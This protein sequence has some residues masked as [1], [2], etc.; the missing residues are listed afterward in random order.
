MDENPLIEKQ[1]KDII[2]KITGVLLNA[3]QNET[4]SEFDGQK[5]A[6]FILDNYKQAQT[7]EQLL[8]FLHKLSS[9]WTVFHECV[10]MFEKS[11]VAKS[12]DEEKMEDIRGKLLTLSQFIN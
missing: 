5:A 12:E 11:N 1:K 8:G 7:Y 6:A 4:L 9:Q 3:Q 10:E 2:H